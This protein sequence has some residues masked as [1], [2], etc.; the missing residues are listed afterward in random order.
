MYHSVVRIH[1]HKNFL[2]TYRLW[3]ISLQN[4]AEFQIKL[5]NPLMF[6]KGGNCILPSCCGGKFK[7]NKCHQNNK[8]F[9]LVNKAMS[10]DKN[11]NILSAFLGFRISQFQEDCPVPQVNYYFSQKSMGLYTFMFQPDVYVFV[12]IIQ[13]QLYY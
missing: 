6:H 1:C 9:P 2:F 12:G 13:Q 7:G 4:Q 3:K 8:I 5:N 10:L 11:H